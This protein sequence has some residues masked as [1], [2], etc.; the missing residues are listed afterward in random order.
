MQWHLIVALAKRIKGEIFGSANVAAAANAGYGVDAF[1]VCPVAQRK[2]AEGSITKAQA[3]AQSGALVNNALEDILK[4]THPDAAFAALEASSHAIAVGDQ[5][6]R[7]LTASP[8][9]HHHAGL[10][11]LFQGNPGPRPPARV[12]RVQ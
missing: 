10:L 11:P 8:S 3:I 7:L 4:M 1:I 9:R 6:R 12:G 5:R 2:L